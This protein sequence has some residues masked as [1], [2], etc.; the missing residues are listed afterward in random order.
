MA[1][2]LSVLL[3]FLHGIGIK[4]SKIVMALYALQLHAS[5]FEVGLLIATYAVVPTLIAVHAGRAT[6]RFGVQRPMLVASLAT[7]LGLLLPLAVDSIWVLYISGSLIGSSNTFFHVANTAQ[8]G[9]LSRPEE[10]AANF[11]TFT[12]GGSLASVAGPVLA[13]WVVDHA[14]YLPAYGTLAVVVCAPVVLLFV[15]RDRFLEAAVSA[16]SATQ[17]AARGN[18]LELLSNARLRDALLIS[19]LIITALDLFNFYMPILGKSIGLTA[20]AIGIIVGTQGAAAAVVRLFMK[21]SVRRFS[22]ERLM[23]VALLLAGA[24]YL[25]LPF[26]HNALALGCVAFLLGLGLGFGQPLSIMLSYTHSPPDRIG[27]ALGVRMGFNKLTQVAVPLVFGSLG[28]AFGLLPI[29]FA[30][31]ALLVCGGTVL[32]RNLA[33]PVANRSTKEQS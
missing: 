30:N 33:R 20:T 32:M 17:K 31:A 10:R 29:F 14:G 28:S 2:Y 26:L 25:L 27:E 5:A 11:G 12:L 6:D 7:A 24:T 19:G 18:L 3:S 9:S 1:L 16:T 4:G 21:Q 23:M 13:G 15:F 8:V 22:V